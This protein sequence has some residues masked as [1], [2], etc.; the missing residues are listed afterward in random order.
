MGWLTLLTAT[1]LAVIQVRVTTVDGDVVTGDLARLS[2]SAVEWSDQSA[3]PSIALDRVSLIERLDGPSPR[4]VIAT[5][6][7]AGGSRI[8]IDGIEAAESTAELTL[9]GAGPLRLPLQQLRWVRFRGPSATV[10]PQWLGLVERPRVADSLV[11]RRAG[12][13][14]DEVSGVVL[15]IEAES[16]S[17]SLDGD[18]MRAPVS[19]LEGVLFR[20][21]GGDRQEPSRSA[22]VLLEDIHGSRWVAESLEATD[23]GAVRIGLGDGV[24]QDLPLEAIRRI[25]LSGSVDF[26]AAQEPV[27]FGYEPGRSIGLTA[28]VLAAWLG[29]QVIEDRDLVIR[30]TSHIEYRVGEGFQSLVGSVGIDPEVTSGEDCVVRILLDSKVVWEQ[31][32]DVADPNPRGFEIP[33]G[34]TRRVRLEVSSG[35]GIELGDTVR[36]RRPRMLK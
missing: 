21:N 14:I 25:E 26:L 22:T 24:L 9:R 2:A 23:T 17:F 5:V 19:R 27:G 31:T 32:L 29:P 11:V 35:D 7:L 30:A 12:D 3:V 10:D 8:V 16:V 34:G 13:A 15:G 20:S 36:F 33:L 1:M 28:D 18:S 4:P 6:G